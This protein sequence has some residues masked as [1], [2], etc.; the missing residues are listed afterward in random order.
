M[1]SK[2]EKQKEFLYELINAISSR[3]AQFSFQIKSNWA[4]D[5]G[6]IP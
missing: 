5:V 3:I 1:G 4:R 2:P 6:D